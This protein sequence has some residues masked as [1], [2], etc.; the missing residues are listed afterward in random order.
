M[1]SDDMNEVNKSTFYSYISYSLELSQ[2]IY[3]RTFGQIGLS[4]KMESVV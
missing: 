3:D 4:T 2:V 1:F